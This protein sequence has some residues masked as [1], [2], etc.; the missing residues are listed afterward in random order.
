[1]IYTT[2]ERVEAYLGRD[3]TTAEEVNI[4][5]LIASVSSAV[6]AYLGREYIDIGDDETDVAVT[7]RYFDSVRSHELFVDDM[8]SVSGI[9]IVTSEGESYQAFTDD[10]YYLYPLNGSVFSSIYFHT[11]GFP[12]RGNAVKVSGKFSSG[13]VPPEVIM[14]VT[15]LVAQSLTNVSSVISPFKKES[16]EGYSY[17]IASS[18]ETVN[19]QNAVIMNTLS[20]LKKITF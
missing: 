13:V 18:G 6:G 15:Q 10:M 1:M 7:T 20:H 4:V 17:E 2:Q 14:A 19:G 9:D 8:L 16:I 11:G 5:A 3:L 12:G